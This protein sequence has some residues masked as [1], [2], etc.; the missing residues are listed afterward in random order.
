MAQVE[1]TCVFRVERLSILV[2][3]SPATR[4]RYSLRD[5]ALIFSSMNRFC[6]SYSRAIR[7]FVGLSV[8]R[9]LV[10]HFLSLQCAR[11]FAQVT[12]RGSVELKYA[13]SRVYKSLPK[14]YNN[15]SHSN[16]VVINRSIA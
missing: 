9:Q 15:R 8:S 6:A 5:A 4:M 12:T 10:N 3:I 16:L 2:T 7:P 13:R 14:V 1:P 11:A